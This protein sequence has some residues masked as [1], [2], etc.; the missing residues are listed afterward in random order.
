MGLGMELFG[1]EKQWIE[2]E[3]HRIERE[4]LMLEFWRA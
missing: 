3:F 4:L 2:S 1:D